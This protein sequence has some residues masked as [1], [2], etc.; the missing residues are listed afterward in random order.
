M[1]EIIL[2]ALSAFGATLA[3][4]GT[5]AIAALAALGASAAVLLGLLIFY[6]AQDSRSDQ[7]LVEKL[8]GALGYATGFLIFP[9]IGVMFIDP[10]FLVSSLSEENIAITLSVLGVVLLIGFFST[11]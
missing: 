11:E 8:K 3:T 9:A 6:Q 5:F 1:R 10:D 2:A 7:K 4:G